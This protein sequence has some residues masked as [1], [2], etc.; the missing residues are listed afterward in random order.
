MILNKNGEWVKS[1]LKE[2]G[3]ALTK[4]KSKTQNINP[5]EGKSGQL[6][7]K[8]KNISKPIKQRKQFIF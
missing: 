2:G 8:T 4:I 6:K 7:D 1:A 3:L 5:Y